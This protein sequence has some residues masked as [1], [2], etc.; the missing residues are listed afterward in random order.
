MLPPT[1][2]A[3]RFLTDHGYAYVMDAHCGVPLDA[4]V[5]T[6]KLNYFTR[7]GR[8]A[9]M[10][11]GFVMHKLTRD[12]ASVHGPKDRGVIATRSSHVTCGQRGPSRL[13]PWLGCNPSVHQSSRN[14]PYSSPCPPSRNAS[15]SSSWATAT[16]SVDRQPPAS[17]KAMFR[18]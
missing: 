13:P 5:P 3:L 7:G 17:R 6:Y 10:P 4:R 15:A 12:S 11:L 16:T 8:G 9:R 1:A 14:H 2:V 18:S